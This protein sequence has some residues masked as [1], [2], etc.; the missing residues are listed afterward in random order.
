ML[1]AARADP[2]APA[3]VVTQQSTARTT[4]LW[5]ARRGP[6]DAVVE[7]L[8]A[9]GAKDEAAMDVE[10]PQGVRGEGGAELV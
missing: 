5:A 4:A 1:L 7:L 10:P 2:D 3:R 6:H 9:A 8:V